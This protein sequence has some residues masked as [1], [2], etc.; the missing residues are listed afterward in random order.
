MMEYVPLITLGFAFA[1]WLNT[2]NL[3]KGLQHIIETKADKPVYG[4]GK[5][6]TGDDLDDYDDD[7]TK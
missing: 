1:A 2:T 3:A 4:M 6:Y 7:E 5:T